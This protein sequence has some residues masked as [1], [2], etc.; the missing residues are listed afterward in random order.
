MGAVEESEKIALY[1]ILVNVAILAI[2]YFSAS[3]TGSIA[4]RAEAYHTMADL[5]AV[6]SVFVGLKI[7]KKSTRSFPY[8]LY[9]LE[10]LMS[11]FLAFGIL[12]TGYEI[13]MDI[14]GTVPV[15]IRK[16]AVA[17]AGLLTVMAVTFLFS[18]Y[19]GRKGKELNSPILMADSAH[20]RSDMLSNTIV[21]FAIVSGMLG[22]QLD[23]LAA[24]A[25]V[26]FI[27]KTGIEILINGARVL[28]DASVDYDTLSKVEKIILDTPQVVE[29]K[30]LKGRNSGRFKFIQGSIVI[31]THD[32]D[33]ANF[34]A[35][36]IERRIKDE[37]T[38]IHQ[39][40]IH[41]EP[42]KKHEIIYAIPLEHDKIKISQHFGEAPIF[43]IAEFKWNENTCEKISIIENPY[44]KVDKGKGILVAELLAGNMVDFVIAKVGF[45]SKGPHYVFLNANIDVIITEE[46]T[47]EEAFGK[48]G[49]M[50]G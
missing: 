47:A 34:I 11:V 44:T 8:G 27:G 23:K 18:K 42:L 36:T 30:S 13:F 19:E 33:R 39:V 9:K 14:I 16:S 29:L 20:I 49:L 31:K 40:L 32:L 10:N 24:L 17:V 5:V 38:N 45:G 46:E 15:Q 3:V 35:D 22:F 12:Y 37:I 2:K 43:L 25:V 6:F 28:L 48:L 21:L 26:A 50:L 7:S 41:Y 1:S 4:L